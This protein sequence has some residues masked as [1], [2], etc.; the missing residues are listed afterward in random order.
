MSYGS[1]ANTVSES[2]RAR[3]EAT[4]TVRPTDVVMVKLKSGALAAAAR[5]EASPRARRLAGA[6]QSVGLL[7]HLLREGLVAS[8][9]PVFAAAAI[10][11]GVAR[12]GMSR[13]IASAAPSRRA[14]GLTSLKVQP[15]VSPDQL[16][17]DLSADPNVEYAYVPAI[18]HPMLTKPK[19]TKVGTDPL[20]ARQWGH[21]A[22]RMHEARKAVKFHDATDIL[23]AVIDSGVDMT[24]PDLKKVVRA[25][26]NFLAPA[27]D[28]RD[29]R[30]HGTHVTGIIA[31]LMNNNVG[32]AGL[33]RAPIANLKALPRNGGAWNASA[34][35]QALARP[36]D[37]KARVVNLSLGGQLD[38][39]ER[40]IIADLIDAGIVVV[41]AMG[42]EFE[43]GNPTSYP[44]A[45]DGVIAVGASDELDR[46]AAFSCTG[47]HISVMA[48]GE[49]ILST[50]PTHESELANTTMYDAWPGTS[51]ATP[52]VAA[53]AALLLAKDPSL[54]PAQV[55]RKL[56][57]SADKVKWQTKRPDKEYGYGRLNI[58]KA[59]A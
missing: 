52:H 30:G 16:V 19:K 5:S 25:Y 48:P 17:N 15:G 6:S 43:E 45:Y 34:Y 42:N 24:H 29:Y 40:D 54:S 13:R 27:E 7:G 32:I 36:I 56:C 47:K 11:D 4:A 38:P 21:G 50:V 37:L 49:R 53:A 46:R 28:D 31:A 23:V 18:K 10:S 39:G 41:A 9:M 55:K 33:C 1:R 59:L 57:T 35:Y 14:Q 2:A 3:R 26:E 51:M 58:A 22:I 8:A 12:A 44:A 20:L